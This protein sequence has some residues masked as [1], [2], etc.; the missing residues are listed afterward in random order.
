VA[1]SPAPPPLSLPRTIETTDER[2]VRRAARSFLMLNCHLS[3]RPGFSGGPISDPRPWS[4]MRPVHRYSP[5]APNARH[6]TC[7][8]CSSRARSMAWMRF[9]VCPV[10]TS[11]LQAI[12]PRHRLAFG[13][14]P[15][16]TSRHSCRWKRR[17]ATMCCG[18]RP[19]LHGLKHD[20]W[21]R[22]RLAH[23]TRTRAAQMALDERCPSTLRVSFQPIVEIWCARPELNRRRPLIW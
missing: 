6:L 10:A 8:G 7:A 18:T 22:S 16:C 20:E 21:N 1:V 23:N 19:S 13:H 11:G 4:L 15:R 2:L 12:D 17:S 5:P 14:G 9:S 3:D